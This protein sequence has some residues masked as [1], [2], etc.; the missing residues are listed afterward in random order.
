M[1]CR[2]GCGSAATV[3]TVG[4]EH[5]GGRQTVEIGPDGNRYAYSPERPEDGGVIT[6]L[7]D[8]AVSYTPERGRITISAEYQAG[9][10]SLRVENTSP[11]M[12]GPPSCGG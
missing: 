5:M 8:N 1:H 11:G 7:M 10:F 9:R 12:T 4:V 3:A 6:N 2:T